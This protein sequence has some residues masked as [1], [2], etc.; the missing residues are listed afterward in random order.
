[1]NALVSSIIG[2]IF[3]GIGL[4]TTLIMVD[5]KG[6]QKDHINNRRLV[7]THRVLGYL[8]FATYLFMLVGMIIR[9]SH[10][11]EELAPRLIVHLVLALAFLPLVCLK[12]LFVR[13]YKL[14]TPHLLFVGSTIFILAFVF[15]VITAGHFF[16]YSSDVRHVSISELDTDVMDESIGRFLIISKCSKCHSMERIFRSFK[17]E[18]GWIETVN[19]MAIIDA[20]N[21]RDYDVK[22]IINF[23]LIQQDRRRDTRESLN[24]K[25]GK[26]LLERKCSFC[27]NMDR[28]FRATKNESEWQST[29][30]RMIKLSN[31]PD[32]LS[33]EEKTEIVSYLLSKKK[34]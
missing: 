20:P 13:R 16:L 23:L 9:I 17:T 25:I 19:R 31:N 3:L 26:S 22:Q 29:V 15:I 11:Q 1:M 21:I 8:F 28:I 18:E 5:R 4:A 10:Y 14:F 6:R 2:A 7:I 12:I 30:E 27:H 32:Y 24:A 33:E 34:E